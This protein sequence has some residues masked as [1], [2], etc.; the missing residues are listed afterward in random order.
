MSSVKPIRSENDLK[1]ALDRLRTLW[2]APDGSEEADEFE[3]LAVLIE[4][5]ERQHYPIPPPEPVDAIRFVM[6]QKGLRP[7]D[8]IPFLGASSRVS[9]VLSGRR[10]LTVEMVRRLHEG[11]GIPYDCLVGV[12]KHVA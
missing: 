1:E 2:N 5:Y 12:S 7:K 6:E 3:V 4:S 10:S 9:E 11:L 8:L